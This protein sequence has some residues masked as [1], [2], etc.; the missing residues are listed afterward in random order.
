MDDFKII[1]LSCRT[2]HSLSLDELTPFQG[3]FK[4]RNNKDV[5]VL[6]GY[7]IEQGF[8]CPF[9]V[10]QHEGQ[11]LILDGHGR[12]L[13]LMQLRNEG[14]ELPKLPVVFIEADDERQARLKILELNN[15]NG[16]FS[17]EVFL[18]YARE[19][20]LNYGDLHIA[21]IDLTDVETRFKPT[22]IPEIGTKTVSQNAIEAAE[23][24]VNTFTPPE[25][26]SDY[27]D[28][29]CPHCSANFSVKVD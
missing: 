14:Y 28:V 22:E 5:D 25:D 1:G 4:L 15:I 7:I 19:L 27:R 2:G 8:S 29:V 11:N 10:W 16:E 17:K 12:Y 9:F 18:D 13:A 6:A 23:E 24:K 21:G 26:K 20:S 3:R